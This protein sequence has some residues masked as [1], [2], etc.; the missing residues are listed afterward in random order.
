[1]SP[2]NRNQVSIAS[3]PFMAARPMLVL[4]LVLAP[5]LLLAGWWRWHGTSELSLGGAYTAE[6]HASAPAPD[7]LGPIGQL[8][9]SAAAV[10]VGSDGQRAYLGVGRRLVIV[11]VAGSTTRERGQGPD[12][13]DAIRAVAVHDDVA[14]LAAGTAGLVSVDVSEPSKPRL[15][16]T[17]ET[18]WI[19]QDVALSTDGRLAYLADGA[20]G[21]RVIDTT[22]PRLPVELGRAD[23]AGEAHGVA[24][25]EGLAFVASWGTGLDIIDVRDVAAPRRIASVPL[26]EASDVALLDGHV[27][28]ADRARGLIVVDA[29]DPMRP[30]VI[31]EHAVAGS[32]ERVAVDSTSKR[33][34]VAARDGGVQRIDLAHPAQPRAVG[35]FS[36]ST[37]AWDVA[38]SPGGLH[39]FVADV[40]AY[41]PAQPGIGGETWRSTHLWGVEAQAPEAR[42]FSGLRVLEANSESDIVERAL[43]LSP[44]FVEGVTA[45]GDSLLLADGYAGLVLADGRDAAH[46]VVGA[47]LATR[48]A[49]HAVIVAED[50]TSAYV[51]DG[52]AGVVSVDL[53]ALRG[54]QHA[55]EPEAAVRWRIDTPGEALGI[56]LYAGLLYVAD[57]EG[58]LR[59]I[60]PASRREVASLSLAGYAWDV[61]VRGGM[62]WVSA[63]QGGL[64]AVSLE[65]PRSPRL[66]HTL[67][68]GDGVIFQ[69]VFDDAR[70]WVAA[71]PSGLVALDVASSGAPN[72]L[73]RVDLNGPVVGL[74]LGPGATQ[75]VVAAGTGGVALVDIADPSAPRRERAWA[76]PG[77]AER[78]SLRDGVV[79]VATERGGLQIV[80]V[81][82]ERRP[83]TRLTLPWLA[84]NKDLR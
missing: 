77:V 19:A 44:G 13:S 72:E 15:L 78:V 66:A 64:H 68:A 70:A 40:G 38:L 71:G 83:A 74:A 82:P 11:D 41:S 33:A 59:V 9:G 60:D 4:V 5:V 48:G 3:L 57:G 1:M 65:D 53:D 35:S 79:Y 7:S 58:G 8:G 17:L 51:A 49:A 76:L 80:R 32:A 73:G 52:P 2:S 29:T 61:T 30:M 6:L 25:R 27:L 81:A 54:A 24:V 43:H 50:G 10:A 75:A 39:A 62:A 56:A 34:W 23:V 69:V 26:A 18:R 31:A 12:L 42:G 22:D 84:H 45:V 55:L 28:V 37:I 63:R 36:T 20:R 67:L 21:L 14:W 46:P 47:S 16:G